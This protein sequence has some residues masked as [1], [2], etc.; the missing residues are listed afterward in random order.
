[1]DVLEN[2]PTTSVCVYK[3]NCSCGISYIG[4]TT[5]RLS[6]RIKEHLPSWLGKGVVKKIN[7]LILENLVNNNHSVNMDEAFKVFY[8]I[9]INLPKGT[10]IRLLNITEALSVSNL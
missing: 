2:G 4:R 5:R 9:P 6:K 7:S 10:R 8:R 1:M 3:F